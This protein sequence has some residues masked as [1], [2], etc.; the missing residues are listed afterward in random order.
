MD[1]KRLS[2]KDKESR[3][4][5]ALAVLFFLAFLLDYVSKAWIVKHVPLGEKIQIIPSFFDFYHVENRGAA[6]S[7]LSGTKVG[8]YVLLLLS[9]V[10]LGLLFYYVFFSKR[11][12]LAFRLPLTLI[13]AG[14]LGNALDRLMDAHVTDFLSFHF[15][16]YSFAIF[17]VADIWICLGALGCMMF[18]F[19][20]S[21]APIEDGVKE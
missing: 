13:M 11:L 4:I 19:L 3:G 20:E 8:T 17:N 10:A 21:K 16:T 9:L 15:G 6:F 12:S 5:L 1:S 14:N 18:I 7:L 2:Q